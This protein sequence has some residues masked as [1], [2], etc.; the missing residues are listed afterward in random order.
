MVPARGLHNREV[1][2]PNVRAF[3]ERAAL[4]FHPLITVNIGQ[5]R[6]DGA[7]AGQIGCDSFVI[8]RLPERVEIRVLNLLQH[9]LCGSVG[10]GQRAAV[11]LAGNRDA[12]SLCDGGNAP[13]FGSG[14]GPVSGVGLGGSKRAG[15]DADR[16]RAERDGSF[17][18]GLEAQ[19]GGFALV[20]F[21]I[22]AVGGDGE[23]G[24]ER[25][26]PDFA[27]ADEVAVR[28]V[29]VATP[30]NAVQT[31]LPNERDDFGW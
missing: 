11:I 29:N 9:G 26:L 17:K 7:Q 1:L 13:G 20:D 30:F 18:D 6:Q 31:G 23:A 12:G 10:V 21:V 22:R 25:Q 14:G 24:V 8:V 19:T 2:P 5:V 3:G 4:V 16:R 15:P 28:R 27:G